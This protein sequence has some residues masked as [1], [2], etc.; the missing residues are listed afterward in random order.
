[1]RRRHAKNGRAG[2][3]HIISELFL[4]ATHRI[5]T[6]DLV[7]ARLELSFWAVKMVAFNIK[8][9]HISVDD[10]FVDFVS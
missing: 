6:Q 3:F 1:M 7:K 8:S 10:T 5:V 9:R 2:S 4:T